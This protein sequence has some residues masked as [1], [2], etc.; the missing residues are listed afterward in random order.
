MPGRRPIRAPGPGAG[1][2]ARVFARVFSGLVAGGFA[3]L[4]ATAAQA[5]SQAPSQAPSQARAGAITWP[6]AQ[7]DPAAESGNSADL[8]LPMPCGGAMAFQKIVVPVAPDNPLSDRRIRLGQTQPETGYS[9]YLRTAFLRG[10]FTGRDAGQSFYFLARYELTE[11]QYQ[12]LMGDCTP[13]ARRGRLARGNLSWFDA[14]DLSRR[15]SEWLLTEARDALP[16]LDGTPPYLRLPTETEW[17]YAARG[18]AQIDPAQFPSRRFFGDG[19]LLEYAQ[20]SAPGSAR[21]RL[22]PVGL[23]RPNPLGLFDIYGNAEELMLEPFRLNAV[24]RTHGQTGGLVTR[25]GSVLSTPEQ[26]YSAQRTEYPMFRASDGLALRSKTFGL[27]LVLGRQVAS[28]DQVL[29]RIRDKWIALTDDTAH[30]TTSPLG[31]LAA[32]IEEETDPQRQGALRQLQLEFRRARE[33]AVTAFGEAA[34]STLLNGA[35]LVGTMIDGQQ[36]ID[37]L[38]DSILGIV[39]RVRICSSSDQCKQFLKTGKRLADQQKALRRFQQTY[40]VSFRSALETLTTDIDQQLA[41]RAFN[42]LQAE[43]SASRQDEILL[44]LRHFGRILSAYRNR[45]DMTLAELQMLVMQR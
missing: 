39:D 3:A 22:L 7:Y 14:V 44:N 45:P 38:R 43:L 34:K 40:L 15:Y 24:G 33:Q 10:P 31:A 4:T 13:P 11:A 25:G 36:K 42:L 41:D 27:R 23:R 28:S 29:R 37:R 9:D 6:V 26:V 20:V 1:L 19:N 5:Q 2:C 30:E 17:E 35:V 21:G 16:A 8:I 18:G 12:A 32:L